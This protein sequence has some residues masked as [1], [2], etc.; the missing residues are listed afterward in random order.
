MGSAYRNPEG[1]NQFQRGGKI[2]IMRVL[3]TP[4][5]RTLSRTAAE[6]VIKAV[7]AKPDL[8]LGLPTGSTP[9]GMYEEIVREYRDEHLD[10]SNMRTFNLDEYVGLLH[11]APKSYHSYMRRHFFQHVNVSPGNINIPEGKPGVDFDAEAERYEKAIREAG[12]IDLL[13][14]GIGTNGH[15]AFN[16]PGA[17]FDSRTR[18]VDLAPETIL[19]AQRHFGNEHVPRKAIT[20]GMGT[21]REARRIVLLASGAHKANAVERAL[22]GPVSESVPASALQLHPRAI[23]ILD[24]TVKKN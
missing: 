21:I 13:I 12:G 2:E 17:P 3:V 22:Q 11:D 14:V 8:T 18:V 23:V 10:F 19:N 15:I 9:L 20:M 24:E 6:L 7:R 1:V 16:E 4:D 5:Y